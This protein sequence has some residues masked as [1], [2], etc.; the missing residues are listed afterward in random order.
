MKMGDVPV[1]YKRVRL[2]YNIFTLA[3]YIHIYV[4]CRSCRF[5][6]SVR[7]ETKMVASVEASKVRCHKC[8]PCS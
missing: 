5:A 3:G 4:K 8:Q 1:K 6:K 2:K 7:G